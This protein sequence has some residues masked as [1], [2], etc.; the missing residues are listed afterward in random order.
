[1]KVF[2]VDDGSKKIETHT[3]V[4]PSKEYGR[5]ICN[6]NQNIAFLFAENHISRKF[7]DEDAVRYIHHLECSKCH[8][9][10]CA[11][12]RF[13]NFCPNCGTMMIAPTLNVNSRK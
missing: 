10:T 6:E 7:N 3:I 5:W 9:V 13:Y 12:N 2:V 1:M 8:K 11:C 4:E